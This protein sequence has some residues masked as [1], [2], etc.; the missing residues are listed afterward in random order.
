VAVLLAHRAQ[1]QALLRRAAGMVS[2]TSPLICAPAHQHDSVAL[3]RSTAHW[4][5]APQSGHSK[6]SGCSVD[7]MVSPAVAMDVA[8]MGSGNERFVPKN[9][10]ANLTQVSSLWVIFHGVAAATIE[11][12]LMAIQNY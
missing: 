5:S 10:E 11:A 1:M 2:R 8:L 7:T 4:L 12:R 6:G 9:G 3:P